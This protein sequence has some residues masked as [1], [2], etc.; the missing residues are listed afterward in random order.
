MSG[1]PGGT[2]SALSPTP[3]ERGSFPLDHDGECA[4]VMHK[5]LDCLRLARGENAHTCRLLAK[6]YL[7]CRMDNGLMTRDSWKN[8]GL[9]ETPP[10]HVTPAESFTS[11]TPT[12]APAHHAAPPV[13]PRG[14]PAPPG[15]VSGAV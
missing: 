8:L 9:P 13:H 12:P 6:Q 7:A 2:L 10:A 3:P 11:S 1:S 15:G 4:A 5:Y 14:P